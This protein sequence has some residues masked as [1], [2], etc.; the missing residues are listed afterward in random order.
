MKQAA[1]RIDRLTS[2][3]KDLYY[4]YL[5]SKSPIDILINR[6]INRKKN[7]QES[8]FIKKSFITQSA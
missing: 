1:G 8:A 5:K 7:F 2:P 3:Y 4:Y 6:A